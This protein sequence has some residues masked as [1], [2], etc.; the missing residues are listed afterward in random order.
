MAVSIDI[1]HIGDVCIEPNEYDGSGDW[2]DLWTW[3]GSFIRVGGCE[4]T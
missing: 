3:K 2:E 1:D 4:R